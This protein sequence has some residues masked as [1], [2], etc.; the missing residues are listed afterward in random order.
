[1]GSSQVGGAVE[2]GGADA[3]APPSERGGAS[4]DMFLWRAPAVAEWER[5]GV[6]AGGGCCGFA[7]GG[8]EG[9]RGDCP[10]GGDAGWA[11]SGGVAY[12]HQP[13]PREGKVYS[14]GGS[15]S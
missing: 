9:R 14:S 5:R 2:L 8:V 4:L 3:G 10:G 6:D 11:C 12:T 13:L 1:M 7:C 15:D